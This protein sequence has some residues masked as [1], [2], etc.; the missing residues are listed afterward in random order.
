MRHRATS[1]CTHSAH[2][3]LQVIEV[4]PKLVQSIMGAQDNLAAALAALLG[5]PNSPM[6]REPVF[7]AMLHS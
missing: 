7:G 6:V 1:C 4:K 2:I 3:A 5:I